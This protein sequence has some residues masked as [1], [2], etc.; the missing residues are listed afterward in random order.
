MPCQS[1]RL[2]SQQAV[3]ASTAMTTSSVL[4][5]STEIA[6]A[7]AQPSTATAAETAKRPTSASPSMPPSSAASETTG[8]AEAR[9]AR[10]GPNRDSSLPSTIS[11]SERSVV[12]ICARMPRA[13][14]AERPGGRRRGYQEHHGKLDARQREEERF[15]GLR[16]RLQ[17]TRPGPQWLPGPRSR[18]GVPPG[19][20]QTDQHGQDE[21][22]PARV[23][24]PPPRED[25]RLINEHRPRPDPTCHHLVPSPC[26]RDKALIRPANPGDSIASSDVCQGNSGMIAVRA[27]RSSR[28]VSG[29]RVMTVLW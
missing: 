4:T 20:P 14:L 28:L 19:D 13:V 26:G 15:P 3:K 29:S 1:G 23:N 6:I 11:E 9:I 16:Q 8:R 5:T 2:S 24:L 7:S 27:G 22:D 18:D 21:E 17:R 12:A 25:Q 10:I